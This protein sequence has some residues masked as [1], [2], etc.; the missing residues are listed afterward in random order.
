MG[1]KIGEA[2]K[3]FVNINN[4]SFS[5]VIWNRGVFDLSFLTDGFSTEM[6]DDLS[7]MINEHLGLSSR[8]VQVIMALGMENSGGCGVQPIKKV[9]G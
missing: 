8:D 4:G 6:V 7:R 9:L 3:A 2:S 5:V 1:P